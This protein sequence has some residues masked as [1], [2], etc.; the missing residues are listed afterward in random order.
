MPLHMVAGAAGTS[1]RLT[2]VFF[3]LLAAWDLGWIRYLADDNC[4][5]V[6]TIEHSA[7]GMAH[8]MPLCPYYVHWTLGCAFITYDAWQTY[9][10]FIIVCFRELLPCDSPINA[11]QWRYSQVGIS[12]KCMLTLANC[13]LYK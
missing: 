3:C 5:L 7:V 1:S 2:G 11:P 8:K 10:V 12:G 9:S 4:T 13:F 6:H